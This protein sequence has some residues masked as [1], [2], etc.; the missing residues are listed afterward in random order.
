[1]FFTRIPH[2]E[3]QRLSHSYEVAHGYCVT[4]KNYSNSTFQSCTIFNFCFQNA[5]QHK[6]CNTIQ[7]MSSILPAL[8]FHLFFFFAVKEDE[9]K[10]RKNFFTK[11]NQK[12]KITIQNEIVSSF[13]QSKVRIQTREMFQHFLFHVQ[14]L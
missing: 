9:L 5:Y 10:Q 3:W 11:I 6:L 12:K 2:I 13:I 4:L 14:L 7:Y 8:F 1:M